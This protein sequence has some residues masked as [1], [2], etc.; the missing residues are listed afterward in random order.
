MSKKTT[1]SF[2]QQGAAGE[3]KLEP[4]TN[5]IEANSFAVLMAQAKE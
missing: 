5:G 2:D 3:P 4:G 1:I